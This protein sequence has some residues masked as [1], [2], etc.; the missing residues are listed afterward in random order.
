MQH[1]SSTGEEM[2]TILPVIREGSPGEAIMT[3]TPEMQVE[4]VEVEIITITSIVVHPLLQHHLEI[5]ITMTEEI[6]ITEVIYISCC[7]MLCLRAVNVAF[8][9]RMRWLVL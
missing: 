3:I 1:I 5:H 6:P 8:L 4:V 7:G 2:I 9:Q